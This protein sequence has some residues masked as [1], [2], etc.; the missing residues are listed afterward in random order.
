MQPKE[1]DNSSV[2]IHMETDEMKHKVAMFAS[3]KGKL[4]VPPGIS[5]MTDPQHIFSFIQVYFKVTL[6]MH[7]RVR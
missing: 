3:G 6:I 5:K 2:N 7:A 1:T 4:V